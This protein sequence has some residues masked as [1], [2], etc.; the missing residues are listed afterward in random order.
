MSEVA[1]GINLGT[2]PPN[3]H[4]NINGADVAGMLMIRDGEGCELLP[5]PG[6]VPEGYNG[7]PLRH[8]F[9]PG[10]LEALQDS[11]GPMHVYDVADIETSTPPAPKFVVERVIPEKAVTLLTGHGGS[12]KSSLALALG[13]HVAA[14]SDFAGLAV[15]KARVVF[16]SLEDGVD[17]VKHRL[18]RIVD[19]YGLPVAAIKDRFTIADG[20]EAG[21][22]MYE[23]SHLGNR[24][25]EPTDAY[26]QLLRMSA[27]ADLVIVD[28]AS[29]GLDANENE[30][31]LVRTFMR[32]LVALVKPRGGAVLLLAHLPKDAAKGGKGE[33]YSGSTAWHNSARS[34]LAMI[35]DDG[36]VRVEH[37]KSNHGTLA[38]P[39]YF[40]WSPAGVLMPSLQPTPAPE[41]APADSEV[42]AAV[43][44]AAFAGMPIP[45]AT[46]GPNTAAKSLA[47]HLDGN[48]SPRV[49]NAGL[50][51]LEAQGKICREFITD[52]SRHR[53]QFWVACA[54]APMCGNA[55]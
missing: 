13:A 29:D 11:A 51:R 44:A 23:F 32:A 2:I 54:N 39:I 53:R 43:S 34:R 8:R 26:E 24:Q 36:T 3:L 19:A 1:D 40:A 18:R 10:E 9:A 47:Q 30:R 35:A 33:S 49:L 20:T 15:R 28:N 17:V 6:S 7:Q 5:T 12:G 50:A 21:A 31:R 55:A 22:L 48:F 27:H 42:L 52:A 41:P 14:G 38:A 4:L 25:L 45:T 16:V 37:Q 46:S